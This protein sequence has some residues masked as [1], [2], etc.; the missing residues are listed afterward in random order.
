MVLPLREL[1]KRGKEGHLD[2]AEAL[3]ERASRHLE[4]TRDKVGTY[5]RQYQHH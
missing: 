5:V 4:L 3:F 2:D 1:E